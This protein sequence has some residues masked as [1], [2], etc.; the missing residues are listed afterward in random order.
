MSTENWALVTGASAGIGEALARE[1]AARGYAVALSA[2]RKERL[3]AI[4]ADL[5]RDHGVRTEVVAADLADPEAPARLAETLS[6]R[7]VEILVNNAGFGSRG[8]FLTLPWSEHAAAIQVMVTALT[9]LTHRFLPAMVERRRGYVLNVASVAGLMP[10]T[11][12]RT[13]YGG[14]KAYVVGFSESLSAEHASD[15]IGVTALCPGFTYSEFHDVVGNRDKVSQLPKALWMDAATVA[16][17]GVEGLLAG[18]PV[19]VNGVPNRLVLSTLRL[20]PRSL[21]RRVVAGRAKATQPT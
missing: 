13:L 17:E 10:G 20:L 12:G 1:L 18:R 15:G 7:R 3:E 8:P 9:E 5:R 2:R 21:A 16:R 19:V 11:P 14:I 4:A 6:D